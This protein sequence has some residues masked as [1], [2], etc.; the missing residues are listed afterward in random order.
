ME[1]GELIDVDIS[2]VWPHE[3]QHFTP[4]LADNLDRLSRELGIRLAL[5]GTEVAVEE[6]SADILA[7]NRED[8]SRVLIENQYGWSDHRHLGQILT[9]R[10]VWKHG[11][12]SGSPNTSTTPTCPRSVGSTNTPQ[13]NSHSSPSACGW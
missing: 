2:E 7:I 4:W 11:P 8:G 10:P 12:W 9:Y 1:F 5:E 3:A 13:T 6:F